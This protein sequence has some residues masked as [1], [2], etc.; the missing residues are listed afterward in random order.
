MAKRIVF[1]GVVLALAVLGP[2][3]LSAVPLNVVSLIELVERLLPDRFRRSPGAELALPRR[4]HSLHP[5]CSGGIDPN[6]KPCPTPS[7]SCVTCGG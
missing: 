1:L 5:K 6:G 2:R 3:S 7:P 4:D